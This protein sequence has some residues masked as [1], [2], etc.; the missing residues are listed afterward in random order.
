VN[1]VTGK[2]LERVYYDKKKRSIM[3]NESI[4][5]GHSRKDNLEGDLELGKWYW[6][7]SE[8]KSSRTH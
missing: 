4:K 7:H 8:R 6:E 2:P 1:G 3:E 5:R